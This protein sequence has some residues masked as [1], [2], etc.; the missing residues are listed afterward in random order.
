MN[1]DL[2]MDVMHQKGRYIILYNSL[3]E[4]GRDKALEYV[5][6]LHKTPKYRK[7]KKD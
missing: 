2:I 5:E 3:N 4:M 7:G 1:L 6:M